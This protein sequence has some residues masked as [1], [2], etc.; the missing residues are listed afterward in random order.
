MAIVITDIGLQAITDAHAGGFLVNM[1]SFAVTEASGVVP[2]PAD[3]GLVGTVVHSADI[4]SIEVLTSA[5][6]RLTLYMSPRVP[7]TGQWGLTEVGIFLNT[8]ELFAHGTFRTP[9]IKNAEFGLKIVVIV[10]AARLGDVINVTFSHENSLAS[11][12][13][14][15]TLVNPAESETNAVIVQDQISNDAHVA[16]RSSASLALRYGQGGLAWAFVGHSMVYRGP[17]TRVSDST[18]DLATGTVGGFWLNDEETVIIQVV[19]GGGLGASR[20]V[21]Y[22]KADDEFTILEKPLT[23]YTSDSI[24]QIWRDS[25]VALPRRYPD[26]PNYYMLSVGENT[27]ASTTPAGVATSK[28]YTQHQVYLRGDGGS[29]FTVSIEALPDI[30]VQNFLVFIDGVQLPTSHFTFSGRTLTTDTPIAADAEVGIVYF[31]EITSTGAALNFSRAEYVVSSPTI[32]TYSLSIIPDTPDNLMVFNDGKFVTKNHYSLQGSSV[33]FTDI[34]PVGLVVLIASANF[35]EEFASSTNMQMSIGM[36]AGD[37]DIIVPVDSFEEQNTVVTV[38]G[39]LVPATAYSVGQRLIT[40]TT[41]LAADATVCVFVS[42]SADAA[43]LND[44]QSGRDTGPVWQDPAGYAISPNKIIPVAKQYIS[45]GGTQAFTVPAV[46]S[47]SSLL[48][49]VN[50]VFQPHSTLVYD[51]AD[52]KVTVAGIPS[53]GLEVD[54]IAFTSSNDLGQRASCLTQVTVTTASTSIPLS[55]SILGL[56]YKPIAVTVGGEYQHRSQYTVDATGLKFKTA[57]PAGQPVEVW[58]FSSEPEVGS[59]ISFSMDETTIIEGQTVYEHRMHG[60][61]VDNSASTQNSLAFIG[62]V[63]QA[64]TDYALSSKN[65]YSDNVTLSDTTGLGGTLM[66]TFLV[67]SGKPKTRLITRAELEANYVTRAMFEAGGGGTGGGVKGDKGDPGPKGDPGLPGPPGTPSGGQTGT[68]T[69]FAILDRDSFIFAATSAGL[70]SNFTGATSTI[71]ILEGKSDVTSSW[72]IT[73]ADSTGVTS[74]LAGATVTVKSFGANNDTG[75]VTFTAT[76]TG[77][78]TLTKHFDLSKAKGAGSGVGTP[79][80]PGPRGSMWFYIG[81][82]TAWDDTAARN[83]ASYNGGPI[84]NDT[85]VETGGKFAET[86]FWNGTAWVAVTSYIDGNL[87]VD[88][89]V[90]ARVMSANSITATNGAIQDLAVKTLKIDGNAVTQAQAVAM[91]GVAQTEI[92]STEANAQTIL[93]LTISTS[94]TGAP[95][96]VWASWAN[97]GARLGTSSAYDSFYSGQYWKMNSLPV[98]SWSECKAHFELKG[99]GGTSGTYKSDSVASTSVYPGY[100]LAAGLQAVFTNVPKGTYVLTLKMYKAGSNFIN[101]AV[102]T[103]TMAALEAKR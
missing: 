12:A 72:N 41:P 55:S 59:C 91:S 51:E 93:S 42:T 36:Q 45:S 16:D 11:T 89:T 102:R 40:L 71:Q 53:G 96:L 10:T 13:A 17:V 66:S 7:L 64:K 85:V 8:G 21:R 47:L 69:V 6:V 20:K 4:Q 1:K 77:Y 80:L 92:S 84:L 97:P 37:T 83:A 67:L 70:V 39:I 19:G 73:K 49:W 3:V 18:F 88:G 9:Y 95:I 65:T 68:A 86:R 38:D 76:R 27:W 90:G 43:P 22:S 2:A 56:K 44:A 46:P 50:G 94:M 74:T 99:V 29:A 35:M 57:L 87:L 98:P 60:A 78:S 31:T 81:G 48:I 32:K 33:T 23:G 75:A 30:T 28:Q 103:A 100:T 25:K 101:F 26:M 34:T 52:A 82:K 54:I 24:L 63:A 5:S 58:A 15:H 61:V 79:G 14:V 62:N